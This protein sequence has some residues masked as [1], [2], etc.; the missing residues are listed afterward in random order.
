MVQQTS[1]DICNFCRKYYDLKIFRSMLEKN[2]N[3]ML[4]HDD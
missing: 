4:P 2:T 3:G 1:D